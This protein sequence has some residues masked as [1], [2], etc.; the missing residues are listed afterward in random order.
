MFYRVYAL[1]LLCFGFESLMLEAPLHNPGRVPH[2]EP[3]VFFAEYINFANDA[4]YQGVQLFSILV[5]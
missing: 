1:T 4:V 3:G 5:R 2:R